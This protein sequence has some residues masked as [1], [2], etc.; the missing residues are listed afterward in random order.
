MISFV[1]IKMIWQLN[2][3]KIKN[4]LDEQEINKS[5]EEPKKLSKFEFLIDGVKKNVRFA[6]YVVMIGL[7]RDFI[8]AA[9]IVLFVDY[10]IF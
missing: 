6:S 1:A 10:P 3:I 5:S 7:V 9:M 8:I 4:G 2:K